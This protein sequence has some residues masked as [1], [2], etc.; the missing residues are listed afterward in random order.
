VIGPR[1]FSASGDWQTTRLDSGTWVSHCPTLRAGTAQDGD[2]REWALLGLAVQTLPDEPNPLEQISASRS[3]AVPD[4]YPAWTGRWL[5]VGN[6]EVHLDASGLLGCFC[7]SSESGEVWASS[8]PALL[9]QAIAPNARLPADPRRLRFEQGLSWYPPPRS[10]LSGIRRLLPSQVLDLDQGTVRPRPLLPPIDPDRGYDETLRLLA[11]AF[12]TAIA[13]LPEDENP[14]W[15]ALSAGLDSRVVAAATE[16]AGVRYV[17]FM[18]ISA[19]MSAGDRLITPRLARALGRELAVHRRG[20]RQRRATTRQRLPL[21]M[22]HSADHVSEG[23][24]QP[25]LHG[26]RDA[27]EGISP[28]GWGFGVG[29]ALGRQQLPARVSDPAEVARR[30]AEAMGEPA[31]ST[32]VDGLCE[33]L[34]WVVETPQKNL[35]WRDRLYI[36][37]R[38]AG[39]QSSK[40]QVYDLVPLERFPAVNS[41]RCYALLLELDE[42][43]RAV[44]QHQR[45]LVELLCPKL[46]AFPANPPESDLGR[47]RVATV[48]LRDDPALE[49]RKVAGRAVGALRRRGPRLTAEAAPQDRRR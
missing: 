5:L 22:A 39:W 44:Q 1:P 47:W 28:G 35:D 41:A 43:R 45:D 40:E 31:G 32:A 49:L 24:A 6:G 2:G 7:G 25:L 34:Q 33:W 20:R 42:A 36:E 10:R 18:R 23:D 8:S 26:V 29:K 11:D 13:R 48:R 4:C 17:P 46:A 9:G 3:A 27:L 38:M 14:L 19:R 37:Q 15:L 21:V 30:L 12:V 16:R